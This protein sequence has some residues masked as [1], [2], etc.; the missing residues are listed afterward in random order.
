[1][2]NIF[3][4]PNRL[5]IQ[6]TARKFAMD[7]VFPI[8]NELDPVKGEFP[9][10]LLEQLGEMGYFGIYVP[11][12][13]GG[14]GLG[15]FEYCLITEELSR[16]WM[17]VASIIAR[18]HTMG[19]QVADKKRSVDLLRQNAKGKRIG[20]VA[21]S[22]PNVGSDLAAVETMAI[23][24]GD[25]W[26]IN[27]EKKWCGHALRADFIYLLAKT[28]IQAG[29]HPSKALKAF[30]IDKERGSFPEG[31]TG[32]AIPKIG[33]HGIESYRLHIKQ[34]RVPHE[35]LA[36]I[37]AETGKNAFDAT[38]KGLAIARVHTAARAIG[39]AK[40][41]LEDALAYAKK[42]VQFGKPIGKFQ[43]IRFKLATMATEIE[44][45]RALMYQ[46]A[47]QIDKGFL[48]HKEAS[49]CKLFAT[50]MAERVTSEALQIFGGNG[51][52]TEVQVERYWR[53]ARLTKIFEG[54][55]E[56]QQK[57]IAN[58]LFRK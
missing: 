56:I 8:A 45:A 6:A 29:E 44:A 43:A 14:M 38:K 17:S 27:G 53:D 3:L 5:R 33:Y 9:E 22:E 42:R 35:N 7:T 30:I 12:E 31:I 16:A 51:Y 34:L 52:T 20:A 19:T 50:E 49:M 4:T 32:E 57:I 46:V 54:T 2:T 36:V 37:R 15:I 26:E 24:K 28:P 13:H 11:K 1:M 10:V 47:D 39:L 21:L 55:S 40:G 25:F 48:S 23:R 41:A 18:G 58:E